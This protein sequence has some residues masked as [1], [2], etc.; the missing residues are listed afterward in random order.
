M[1]D[2]PMKY[3]NITWPAVRQVLRIG[4]HFISIRRSGVTWACS[5]TS[6]YL[7]YDAPLNQYLMTPIID[8]HYHL[9]ANFET[10]K[11]LTIDLFL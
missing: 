6:Q 3:K 5:A 8:I 11:T 4:P 7:F 10:D 9:N 1:D 2:F